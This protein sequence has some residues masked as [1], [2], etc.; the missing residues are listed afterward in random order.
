ME[1]ELTEFYVIPSNPRRFVKVTPR[2]SN[3][4]ND[5]TFEFQTNFKAFVISM[6]L[7]PLNIV[8]LAALPGLLRKQLASK[9]RI[10]GSRCLDRASLQVSGSTGAELERF[11]NCKELELI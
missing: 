6:C 3:A 9:V 11:W 5:S 1:L 4:A 10:E 8:I 2:H 7:Q